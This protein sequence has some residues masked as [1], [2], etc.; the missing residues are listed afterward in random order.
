MGFVTVFTISRSAPSAQAILEVSRQRMI[1]IQPKIGKGE[2]QPPAPQG[3]G[4]AGY[5]L[6]TVLVRAPVS[7]AALMKPVNARFRDAGFGS[8]A[9]SVGAGA[10]E[11]RRHD[12]DKRSLDAI[13]Y[14]LDRA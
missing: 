3:K 7:S 6:N 4:R 1:S 13:Q 10:H 14:L 5:H 11:V 8:P 12:Q 2:R 9:T